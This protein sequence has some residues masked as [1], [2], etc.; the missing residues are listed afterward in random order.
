MCPAAEDTISAP[1]LSTLAGYLAQRSNVCAKVVDRKGQVSGLP[2]RG[3]EWLDGAPEEAGAAV[4][5]AFWDGEQKEAAS[6]AVGCAFAGKP[7]EFVGTFGPDG[8]L[9]VWEIE[10][11]PLE[12][13]ADA[14]SQ[15]L[16][17]WARLPGQRAET[18]TDSETLRGVDSAFRALSGALG[19][20]RNGAGALRKAGGL[21][22]ESARELAETLE[23]ASRSAAQAIEDL[24]ALLGANPQAQA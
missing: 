15:V 14:V 20:T 5:Q 1:A 11:L 17:L 4:W 23:S 13:D 19:V 10:I 24:A 12:W 21:D 22:A 16:V 2:R 8:A 7:C 3:L 6:A 18:G 9:G